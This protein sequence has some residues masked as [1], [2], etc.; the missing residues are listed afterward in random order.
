MTGNMKI[1]NTLGET[2]KY[3]LKNNNPGWQKLADFW[4][5]QEWPQS[6]LSSAYLLSRT[7][8]ATLLLNNHYF[9]HNYK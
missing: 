2:E 3:G 7:P 1:E 4:R 9:L 5:A 8:S 6:F